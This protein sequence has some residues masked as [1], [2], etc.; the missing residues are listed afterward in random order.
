LPE[1]IID[2]DAVLKD[3]NYQTLKHTPEFADNKKPD[4]PTNRILSSMLSKERLAFIL[5][6]GLAYVKETSGLQKHIMRYPQLFATKAIASKLDE[7]IRKGII[8]HTQGSGKTALAYYNTHFLTDY[9]QNKGVIAKFYFIVDR[10]DL[11]IQ[12]SDEFTKRGLKVHKVNSREAFAKDLKKAGAVDNDKGLREI[13]VVNI[14]KF[15]DDPNATK[16]T[17]YDINVQR[18]YFL[19]FIKKENLI[20]D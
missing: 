9:F 2:E 18:I 11:A 12:A 17:D 19:S 4:T 14:H 6:Y 15:Q 16:G 7:G 5:R 10:I 8:W 20:I 13:T 1:Y 3:N